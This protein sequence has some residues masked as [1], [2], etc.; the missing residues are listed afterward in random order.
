MRV[1]SKTKRIS[2]NFEDIVKLFPELQFW[3]DDCLVM[4]SKQ[5]DRTLVK[6]TARKERRKLRNLRNIANGGM[7]GKS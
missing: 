7:R 5:D 1:I 4:Q 2:R 3:E 6:A